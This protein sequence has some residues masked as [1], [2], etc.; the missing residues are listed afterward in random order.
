VG[1]PVVTSRR[2]RSMAWPFILILLGVIFLL[3]NLGIVSH[4]RLAM[5]FAHYWPVL[6]IL[7]GVIKLVEYQQA[8]R[9]N[10]PAP[11]IGGGGVVLMV[12]LV[13][14]GL[15][16]THAANF[17]WDEL[18]D[19]IDLGDSDIDIPGFG[20][21]F[22][23]DDQLAQALPAG[24]GVKIVNDRGAV[25]VSVSNDDQL[26]V[27]V[28][29][30]I[31]ADEQSDADKWNT[32]TKPQVTVSGN[33]VTI[34]A[35]TM[36]AGEHPVVADLDVSI[37]RKAA[38]T[39][40]SK[41][42]DVSVIGRDGAVDITNQKG[43]VSVEDVDGNVNLN[44]DR[45]S[46]RVTNIS[47]DVSVDGHS[48][49]VSLNDIRGFARLNGEFSESL[50]LSKIAK[51]VS[52]K[53]SRTDLEFSKLDG[54]LD[55]DQ[56]DL[57][58]KDLAGPLRLITRSKDVN[59]E[60][61][62]GDARVSNENGSVDFELASAGNVQIDNRSGDIKVTVP[63]KV[64]FK[65][66]ARSRGGE[67]Q[68]DFDKLKVENDDNNGTLTGTIGSGIARLVLNNEHGT[69]ELRKSDESAAPK[70]EPPRVPKAPR[71][72]KTPDGEM[73]PTEN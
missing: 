56:G 2:R 68:S 59:L 24:S 29:K 5:L 25:N 60:G 35:N 66:D 44:L 45:S 46:A 73:A 15:M 12:F 40:A 63:N 42:G 8:K 53:S 33:L 64:G 1:S 48:N 14:F 52:F 62:S 34:N 54:D 49:E 28:R 39:I 65:V 38:L 27:T 71:A 18:R 21:T 16:A 4:G 55:L 19:Q 6:L 7:W 36:G 30:K 50:K 10:L 3:A 69:I 43:D 41:R 11:G 17:H 13:I 61:V 31:R 57:R 72:P 58:A 23:Y 9:D 22:N 37:P 70:P 32:S 20:K 47:G 26:R 67:V 51:T